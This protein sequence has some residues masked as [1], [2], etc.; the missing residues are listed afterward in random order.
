MTEEDNT[1][2]L[3]QLLK[4]RKEGDF[5]SNPEAAAKTEAMLLRKAKELGI[6]RPADTKAAERLK[7]E[8]RSAFS[9]PPESYEPLTA[10][11]VI[12]RAT[13]DILPDP[14]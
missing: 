1:Q 14:E 9:A 11:E 12:S 7:N 13:K 4:Q 8:L 6:D 2:L 10:G 3:G 5:V